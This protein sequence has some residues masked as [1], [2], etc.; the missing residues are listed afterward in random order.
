[1]KLIRKKIANLRK[2]LR[3]HDY[4]YYIKDSP[5]I[6]DVQ[7]DQMILQLKKLE[8]DN[9]SLVEP[10]SSTQKIGGGIF[11]KYNQVQHNMPMLSLDNVFDE[12]S[13]LLFNN[14]INNK[15][16]N[17]N[18]IRY[19]C[20]LK[21]DGLAVNIT[22]K[23]SLLVKAA[24]RGDGFFGENI[25]DN[26]LTIKS[27]PSK[28]QGINIPDFLEVRGE[29]FMTQSDFENLNKEHKLQNK[30]IFAN[31]RNAAAG[32]L[33]HLNPQVTAMRPL[34][35]FCYGLGSVK[36]KTL[37]FSHIQ[38][39]KQL[40]KWGLPVSKHI[41]LACSTDEVINFY[42][43]IKKIRYTL[44]FDIDG[45]VIKVDSHEI[46]EKLGCIA[47]VPRWAI[48][49]KF[50]AQEKT[51][52]VKEVKFQVG[53]TGIITP[54]AVLRLVKLAGVNIKR[55]TL[56]NSDEINRL[57][58]HIG[59]KV[60][61]RRAGDVI[62]QVMSVILSERLNNSSKV[63]FPIKCPICK[64]N[65][66]RLE[67]EVIARCTGGLTCKAQKNSLLKHFISSK[68]MN[69]Q[70][71]GNNLIEKLIDKKY[72]KTPVDLFLLTKKKLINLDR[73]GLKSAQNILNSL[74]KAKHTSLP[75]FIYSL[76]I[77]E[78]GEVTSSNLANYFI[79]LDK[80]INADINTLINIKNIG[81]KTAINIIHFMNEENN[82]KII[83]SLINDI[84]IR[85]TSVIKK[86]LKQSSNY[87]HGK[88]VVLSGSFMNIKRNEIKLKL[89][90]LGAIVKNHVS[91]KTN[92]LICNTAISNKLIK[93]QKLGIKII[94]EKEMYNII[95]N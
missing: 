19:C 63:I 45:I 28:L 55:A 4:L 89:I 75:R 24:T 84:G 85:W 20:E 29:V 64:S 67:G 68:A 65:I 73:M 9:P 23:K 92:L 33:R 17:K 93:A 49:F 34:R 69:I 71:I 3:Y 53:R 12:R 6:P 59:D 15:L 72:V 54:V 44:G 22:Y 62:P 76:G 30:K 46:R 91:K 78:V 13:F 1:M 31:P 35:F 80:L 42:Q 47:K 37:S 82:L 41:R 43:D 56:H 77:R 25:T 70:G 88:V 51:T 27:I 39:L 58:L 74:E 57:D 5:E 90:E 81:L 48:A 79:T 18:I 61:I 14:R 66:E 40:E 95:E 16:K 94:N 38:N 10:Y 52:Y 2:L 8:K 87:F 21:I 36:G 60:V 11:K 26:I 7:Y 50:P 32:S 86:N 83:N